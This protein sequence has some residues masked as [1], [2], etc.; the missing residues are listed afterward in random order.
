MPLLLCT[1][2][3]SMNLVTFCCVAE[4]WEGLARCWGRGAPGAAPHA[5]ACP[6][7]RLPRACGRG[8][9]VPA[10]SGVRG[11]QRRGRGALLLPSPCR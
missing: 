5:H 11:Q 6:L 3:V 1:R 2:Q 10:A 9:V 8:A 7:P 4:G